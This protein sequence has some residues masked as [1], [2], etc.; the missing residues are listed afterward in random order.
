[1]TTPGNFPSSTHYYWAD[2]DAW[3]WCAKCYIQEKKWP[4]F[5]WFRE[6]IS[7]VFKVLGSFTTQP[8][9]EGG[10]LMTWGSASLEWNELFS[11]MWPLRGHVSHWQSLIRLLMS[12]E[13]S[14][15]GAR[16]RPGQVRAP[17]QHSA[18]ITLLTNFVHILWHHILL[19]AFQNF[20]L[21]TF[22]MELKEN[23][24]FLSREKVLRSSQTIDCNIIKNILIRMISLEDCEGYYNPTLCQRN[25]WQQLML[26]GGNVEVF[27]LEHQTAAIIWSS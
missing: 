10:F 7:S 19:K 22:S 17:S 26:G 5:H 3:G 11:T 4:Y 23:P 6:Q 13:S 8:L 20:Y 12:S 27:S 2:D 24:Y 18:A 21:F 16:P 1:M 14:G 15:P 9:P 25:L